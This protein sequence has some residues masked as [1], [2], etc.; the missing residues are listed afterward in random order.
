M[1]V[2][3][4]PR[5]ILKYLN[6]LY[7]IDVLTGKQIGYLLGLSE[8]TVVKYLS[9]LK[10]F[11]CV[12]NVHCSG[13]H[14]WHL[15][16]SG[17]MLLEKILGKSLPTYSTTV[18]QSHKT[19][20]N[21]NTSHNVNCSNVLMAL[22]QSSVEGKHGLWEWFGPTYTRT[23]YMVQRD[24]E[25]FKRTLYNPDAFISFYSNG[26][27]GR[28]YVE[29]DSGVQYGTTIETKVIKAHSTLNLSK[30]NN[31]DIVIG[32]IT[33]GGEKR[34]RY[35]MSCLSAYY[36]G[37]HRP[38]TVAIAC[39]NDIIE[40]R[41]WGDIWLTN[42]GVNQVSF[43]VLGKYIWEE[44]NQPL[45]IGA[46]SLSNDMEEGESEEYLDKDQAR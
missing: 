14:Y 3:T 8:H 18:T 42:H 5:T 12:I 28:M 19:K 24:N 37:H 41:G 11:G 16:P 10:R 45:L 31:E 46:G 33:Y 9:K 32:F 6:V 40:G 39:Y 34:K 25:L 2:I 1:A 15:L 13:S 23:L 44:E 35:L 27:Y 30:E 22:V 43:E 21:Q 26:R 20:G 4:N 36:R 38:V 7:T 29:Y 17:V